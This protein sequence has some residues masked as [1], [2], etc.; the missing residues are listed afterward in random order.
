MSEKAIE[1]MNDQIHLDRDA[2]KAYEE[3][4]SSCDTQEFKDQ[5]TQFKS[6]H[7]RHVTE[8]SALVRQYG[9][10]PV[11]TTDIKGF[12]IQAFTKITAHGDRSALFAMRG[13]E[14]ITNKS[15]EKALE[16]ELPDDVRALLQRN[17]DDE[18]RHLAWIEETIKARAWKDDEP[19]APAP[20]PPAAPA[21]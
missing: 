21:P 5:L 6:D 17:L 12:F 13:N 9:G 11:E 14:K 1:V 2:I 16:N 4:I 10:T 20:P 19:E 15:Y 8:L 7:E 3:A 18:R